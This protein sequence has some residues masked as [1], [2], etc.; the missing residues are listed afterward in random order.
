MLNFAKSNDLRLTNTFFRHKPPH[1]TTWEA[2][3]RTNKVIDRQSGTERRA[4]YRNQIDYIL[5]K[6][7]RGVKI[8]NSRSYGGMITTS[9]HKLVMTHC[10][11]KW[12]YTN[13]SKAEPQIHIDNLRNENLKDE[14]QK[15]VTKIMSEN[16]SHENNQ[17]KWIT[18]VKATTTAAKNI[19]GIK[20]K[21]KHSCNPQ[22][23]ELSKKQKN[24]RLQI[25][26]AKLE[27]KQS[28]RKERNEILTTVHRLVKDQ[29]NEKIDQLL[30]E[31]EKTKNDSTRMFQAIKHI[32]RCK[33]KTPLLINT[34]EG[35]LTA[36]EIE[37]TKLIANHFKNQFFKNKN[38][39]TNFNPT[40]MKQP[41]TSEEVEKAVKSLNN[42]KSSGKDGVKAE[43][44]KHAPTVVFEEIAE[45]IN[46]T[47]RTGN[48]PKE[49]NEGIITAIQKPGK[50][51]GP[52]ENLRPITLLSMLRKILAICMKKRI[53]E[54]LDAEIPPSQ[55][56]YRAG[57]ST[58]EHVFA[59]K[60]MAE[61]AITSKRYTVYILMLDMSKAFDTVNRN[62]L[63]NDLAK[64]LNQ[65]EMHLI[66]IMLNTKLQVRC[67]NSLSDVFHTD[68]GV[69]QGD[70]LS[71]NQF[72]FYLAKAL[73][74]DIPN[75]EHNY[76]NLTD[77]RKSMQIL[78]EHNYST[79][80]NDKVNINQEYA[81]DLSIVTTNPNTISYNKSYLPPLLNERD[82]QINASKTEEFEIKRNGN[83]DWKNANF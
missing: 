59:T 2:P 12:P 13:I 70:S 52:I 57:R 76:A 25:D 73:N 38:V 10:T 64:V 19:L 53:I 81:D 44:L 41:F 47:A 67:G 63:Q 30:L 32:Q 77:T 40:P 56:A 60:I 74:P 22:I 49:L 6:K 39:M 11:F 21:H 7:H 35:R 36:N 4:R 62:I 83:T 24:I 58:T 5:V 15:E 71:A 78:N 23:I 45:I 43:M 20:P 54:R 33:P 31:I 69:P 27:N 79:A 55:A 16:S 50:P 9:D 8:N 72:T 68:T 51:K 37:Q 28:L 61:K 80:I 26:T 3:E 34:K 14:Y 29:E 75:E 17:Q 82:L 48:H 66:S 18:I 46:E 65:D 42:N 1:I